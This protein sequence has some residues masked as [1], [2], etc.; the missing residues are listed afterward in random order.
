M[1]QQ[2]LSLNLIFDQFYLPEGCELYLIHPRTKEF[3]GAYTSMNNNAT[4]ELGTELINGSEL[5]VQVFIPTH[6]VDRPM[7]RIGTITHGYRSLGDY[8]KKQAKDLNDSGDCNIDV[9]CPL[10]DGWEEQ[11]RAVALIIANGNAACTG[12]L[13]NN[14]RQD[15]TPYFLTANH[16]GTNVTNWVFR[17][18]WESPAPSC[19]TTANS[20]PDNDFDSMNGASLIANNSGSDFSLVRFNNEIPLDYNVFFAGWDKTDVMNG[21]STG[22]HHPSGDIKKICRENETVYTRTI[23]FNGNNNTKIWQIDNWDQG[24]TEP[25]SSGSPLFNQNGQIIGQLA[26]GSAACNGTN[27][28]NEEDWYGRFAASWDDGSAPN[29]RLRDWLDPINANVDT[30]PGYDPKKSNLNVDLRMI[31]VL[32]INTTNCEATI[33]GNLS[34]IAVGANQGKDLS[35]IHI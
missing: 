14:T 34:P 9:N 19:A 35:L 20:G 27:D 15:G 1:A 26:G 25:G 4:Q 24:V 2:A 8:A 5:I 32:G 7:L 31:S 11:I 3:V 22:I 18:N 29:Q 28:N 33:T 21:P 10:G 13:I 6:V 30:L 12:S 16:C 17:F 23:D